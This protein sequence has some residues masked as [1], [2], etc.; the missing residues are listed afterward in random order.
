MRQYFRCHVLPPIGD[1]LLLIV[2]KSIRLKTNA[3]WTAFKVS[4]DERGL[5]SSGVLFRSFRVAKM[6]ELVAVWQWLFLWTAWLR[7]HYEMSE[8]LKLF[9]NDRKQ[10]ENEHDTSFR[11]LCNQCIVSQ[12]PQ[13]L[14][15]AFSWAAQRTGGVLRTVHTREYWMC[16]RAATSSS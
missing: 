5:M 12:P 10:V 8:C 11:R 4:Y 7:D 15:K 1:V 16:I 3:F 2:A 13:L 6:Q 14:Q 9:N